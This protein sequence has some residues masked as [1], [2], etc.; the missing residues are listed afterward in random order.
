MI[1]M[2][3]SGVCTLT[4]LH[5][6]AYALRHPIPVRVEWDDE[7]KYF[8]AYEDALGLWHGTGNSPEEA[9]GVLEEVM[10]GVYAD[11]E[12]DQDRLHP[13][14]RRQLEQMRRVIAYAG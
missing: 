7:M 12:K 13:R 11:L 2:E 10:L 9:I 14:M 1:D 4:K 5:N 6:P 3:K 8:I